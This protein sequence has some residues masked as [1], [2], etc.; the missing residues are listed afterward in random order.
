M[1]L[2]S[3]LEAR[4]TPAVTT[5][6]RG[7]ARGGFS[8]PARLLR[9]ANLLLLAML[10]LFVLLF[11][12][13]RTRLRL[14]QQVT[15]LKQAEASLRIDRELAKLRIPY[16]AVIWDTKA[17]RTISETRAAVCKEMELKTI[18][19]YSAVLQDQPIDWDIDKAEHPESNCWNASFENYFLNEYLNGC[20][21][22][23]MSIKRQDTPLGEAVARKDEQVLR[24]I[25]L[26]V[27]RALKSTEP[28]IALASCQLWLALFEPNADVLA[29][30]GEFVT[31]DNRASYTSASGD[32][33]DD[34]SSDMIESVRLIDQHALAIS[35]P[36]DVKSGRAYRKAIR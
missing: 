20:H 1:N 32:T 2:N 5:P 12:E 30:L 8:A 25:R 35:Y 18:T 33:Y 13:H 6:V 27:G 3:E 11:F 9:P 29:R 22:I 16:E 31:K 4:T 36:D 26:H 15:Q 21:S 34:Y 23:C 7:R 28:H 17:F 24:V 19:P 14:Q 10:T